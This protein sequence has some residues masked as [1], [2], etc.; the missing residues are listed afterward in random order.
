MFSL[1]YFLFSLSSLLFIFTFS[2][3]NIP[4]K[5]KLI[6]NEMLI[7]EWMHAHEESLG[8]EKVFR[9]KEY[10]FKLSRGRE[11]ITLQEGGVLLYSTLSPNDRTVQYEGSWLISGKQLILNY[12]EKQ[13][14]YTI[15]EVSSS[16]LKLK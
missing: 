8:K 1:R 7:G 10:A 11:K 12:Q 5:S 6:S 16:I 15:L 3:S 2:C 4:T 14:K 13:F 9:P